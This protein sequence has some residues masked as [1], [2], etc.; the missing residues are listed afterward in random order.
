MTRTIMGK[1]CDYLEDLDCLRLNKPDVAFFNIRK[2]IM[3]LVPPGYKIQ[4]LPS[5]FNTIDSE[6]IGT[7][8]KDNTADFLIDTPKKVLFSIAV[9]MF[10]YN[11]GVN[12]VRVVLLKFHEFEGQMDQGGVEEET[13]G[14]EQLKPKAKGEADA[15]NVDDPQNIPPKK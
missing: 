6:R 14:G 5:F 8:L 3:K 4:L 2:E 13:P 9:K 15:T 10:P 11:H 1:Y 7:V 12:S